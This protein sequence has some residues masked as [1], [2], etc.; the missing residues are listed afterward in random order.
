MAMLLFW[1]LELS[2]SM[3]GVSPIVDDLWRADEID[4]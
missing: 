4:I 1:S 3:S 2:I